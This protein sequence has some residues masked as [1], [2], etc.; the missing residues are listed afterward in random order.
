MIPIRAMLKQAEKFTIDNSPGILTAMGVVGTVATAVLTHK[1][2]TK[3]ERILALEYDT[4]LRESR[5]PGDEVITRKESVALVWKLY[6]APVSAGTITIGCIFGANHIGTRRA[7]AIAAAYT[8]TEKAYEEYKERVVETIGE[9]KERA[10]RDDIAQRRV[11]ANPLNEN[12][13]VIVGTGD[14]R[15][16]DTWSGR[17]FESYVE[18]IKRAMNQVNYLV[19]SHG[20]ATLTDFYDAVGL[21][22]TQESDEIGWSS[23]KL[24][25]LTF[26]TAMSEDGRPCVTFTFTVTPV[27]DHRR[28]H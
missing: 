14:V 8:I 3:A 9:S 28:F 24:L 25:D 12:N 18:E 6:I 15:C 11:D 22:R 26:S 27:R 1:A 10:I 17:Y 23:D 7:A 21:S 19:N 5:V 2:A 16:M 13:V 4:R 20:Y